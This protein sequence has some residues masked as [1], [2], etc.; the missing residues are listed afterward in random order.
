MKTRNAVASLVAACAIGL[1]NF[2]QAQ[3]LLRALQ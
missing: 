1:C 3:E 2:A